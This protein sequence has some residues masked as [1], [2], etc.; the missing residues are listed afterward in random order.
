M[1]Q[2]SIKPAVLLFSISLATFFLLSFSTTIGLRP[3]EAR[4]SAK[5]TACL[6]DATLFVDKN[7]TGSDNG[8]SW[9]NAYV[10]L[11]DALV[12]ADD[13]VTCVG[14]TV[15]IWVA[16]GIYTPGVGTTDSFVLLNDVSLYGGFVGTETVMTERD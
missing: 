7:A 8:S 12:D 9:S 10:D 11:Q 4:S 6:A 16:S 2:H 14:G 13:F 5:D 15:D 3:A 1:K